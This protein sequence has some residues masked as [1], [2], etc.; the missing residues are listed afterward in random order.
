[1]PLAVGRLR[2]AVR[3]S[4]DMR[5]DSPQKEFANQIASRV[6]RGIGQAVVEHQRRSP[7]TLRIVEVRNGAGGEV[8]EDAGVVRAPMA[9]IATRNEC[10]RNSVEGARADAAF[11]PVKIAGILV[12]EGWINSAAKEIAR[13]VIGKC[14]SIAFSIAG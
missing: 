7:V 12:E 10:R 4:R 13:G 14:R 6:G 11:A 9:T 5:S 8:A 1:L 2:L 3:A